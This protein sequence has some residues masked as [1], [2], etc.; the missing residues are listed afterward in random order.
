[1]PTLRQDAI[2]LIKRWEGLRLEA[3][4]DATGVWTIGYGHTGASGYPP[5]VGKG[6]RISELDAENILFKDLKLLACR[7]DSEVDVFI[8]DNQFGALVSFVFN[9]GTAALNRSTLLR[10]LNS[11]DY[12]GAAREFGRWN[13]AR[14]NGK[15]QA[16]RGLTMRRKAERELF[17]RAP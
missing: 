10:K 7:V 8:N 12:A 6:L 1:M 16:V 9:I 17:E 4:Q 15:L 2:D 13:K 11:G 14:I 3:Y 5:S